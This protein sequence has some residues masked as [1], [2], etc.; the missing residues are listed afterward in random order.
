MPARPCKNCGSVFAF[1]PYRET[2]ARFCSRKCR[3]GWLA[4]N[5]AGWGGPGPRAFGNKYRA[6]LRPS[7]AFPSGHIPWNKNRKGIRL[8]PASEFKPGPRPDQ[9]AEIGAVRIRRPKNKPPRAFVKIEQP[10]KWKLR[11]VKV[12]EDARGSVPR[13]YVIHHEDRNPLN[14]DLANLRCLTRAEHALEHA[15]ERAVAW[16]S[17]FE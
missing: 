5:V 14:D 13:G 17:S 3:A 1:P 6:G 4:Q 10:N 12:W 9:R 2:T 15:R 16:M 11:A 7:N 8:S